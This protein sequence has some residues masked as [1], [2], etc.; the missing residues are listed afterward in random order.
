M[1]LTKP[2]GMVVAIM[3]AFPAVWEPAT[4]AHTQ[5]HDPA[6]VGGMQHP[7]QGPRVYL[8]P[9]VDKASPTKGRGRNHSALTSINHTHT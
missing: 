2:T 9:D 5:R 4:T 7:P 6:E 3:N 1:C 8:V